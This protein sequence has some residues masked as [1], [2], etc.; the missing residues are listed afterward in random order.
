MTD[1]LSCEKMYRDTGCDLVMIGRGSYG[2]PWVFEEI[3]HYFETG[4]LLPPKSLE[5]KMK[6]DKELI[7]AAALLHDIGR[8]MEYK[9]GSPH[10]E[11]GAKL[12]EKILLHADFNS[13]EI[14]TICHA[15][16]CHKSESDG[17]LLSSFLYRADKLSRCCFR[18]EAYDEC[19][20]DEGMK[21]KT[22][23]Y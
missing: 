17:D 21:N 18:C 2:K 14:K 19:Y 7:Y 9:D 13:D 5:E 8:A 12:A 11:M 1:P 10:H 3:R 15:I 16:T 6:I 4:E 23:R 22:I 20:W